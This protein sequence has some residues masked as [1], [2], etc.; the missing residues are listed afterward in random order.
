MKR[1]KDD[2]IDMLIMAKVP[3]LVDSEIL[4]VF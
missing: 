1:L 2:M 3:V 4:L